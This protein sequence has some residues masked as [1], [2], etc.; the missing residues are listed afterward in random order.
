[1]LGSGVGPHKFGCWMPGFGIW[2]RRCFGIK[3]LFS[4][5][6]RRGG[7]T[8][9]K[10]ES[11]APAALPEASHCAGSA[12]KKMPLLTLDGAVSLRQEQA[13]A[14]LCAAPRRACPRCVCVSV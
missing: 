14:C 9:L 2:G 11:L 7:Q 6:Q 4:A 5:H 10:L 8:S 3:C 12:I 1:M 13:A